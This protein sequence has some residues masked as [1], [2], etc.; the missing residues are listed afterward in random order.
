MLHNTHL[1]DKAGSPEAW[2]LSISRFSPELLVVE[3]DFGA[4]WYQ[5]RIATP[6]CKQEWRGYDV[7][8]GTAG[9]DWLMFG[10]RQR[11]AMGKTQKSGQRNP[12]QQWARQQKRGQVQAQVLGQVP[13]KRVVR[14]V[15]VSIETGNKLCSTALLYKAR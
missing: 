12:G 6:R 7:E 5:L 4:C 14:T 15:L 9:S 13:G 3:F 10:S 11:L 8:D 1:A 2:G